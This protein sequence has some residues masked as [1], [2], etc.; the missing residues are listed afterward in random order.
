M[1]HTHA[2]FIDRKAKMLYNNDLARNFKIGLNAEI[3]IG[4]ENGL[5]LSP[6]YIHCVITFK[7]SYK[8]ILQIRKT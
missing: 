3:K 7:K 6:H 5:S 1:L 8:I 2:V 4:L